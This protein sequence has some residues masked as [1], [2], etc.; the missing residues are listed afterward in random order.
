MWGKSEEG[1]LQVEKNDKMW[2]GVKNKEKFEKVKNKEMLEKVK[3]NECEEA[4]GEQVRNLLFW[5]HLL[6]QKSNF[7]ALKNQALNVRFYNLR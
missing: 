4:W 7:N 1:K 3:K 2:E 6:G 5:N